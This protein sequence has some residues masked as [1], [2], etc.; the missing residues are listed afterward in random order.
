MTRCLRSIAGFT[1]VEM[2]IALTLM[3]L[4]VLGMASA[5]R[6]MGQT[7]DR[8]DQRIGLAEDVQITMAFTSDVLGRLSER[9]R[10]LERANDSVFLFSGQPQVVTWLGIMP[11]RHGM[12][13]RYFFRLGLETSHGASALVLRYQPWRGESEFPDLVGGHSRVLVSDVVGFGIDYG[14]AG[15]RPNQWISLWRSSDSLPQRIR[16]DVV[17]RQGRWP[18][19]IVP[20]EPLPAGGA[21]ASRFA[22][23]GR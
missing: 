18:L 10:A 21:G 20:I 8:I 14:G 3:S 19:W 6:T 17:T 4:L 23:G 12:G 2:L 5:L 1:L 7:Q 15:M 9:R 13:G 11:P 16:L 22:V